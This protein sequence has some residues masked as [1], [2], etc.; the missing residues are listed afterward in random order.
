M[1]IVPTARSG[2]CEI[3]GVSTYNQGLCELSGL[4]AI[5]DIHEKCRAAA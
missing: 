2:S 4:G 1:A 5:R 3:P